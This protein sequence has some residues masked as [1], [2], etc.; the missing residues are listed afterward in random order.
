MDGRHPS[1][2]KQSTCC[3]IKLSHR[4]S[5]SCVIGP[6]MGIEWSRLLRTGV[7]RNADWCVTDY[8]LHSQAYGKTRLRR[9]GQR[10]Q[11]Q[12]PDD[13]YWAS[14]EVGYRCY[15]I[16]DAEAD[17]PR[18]I[19]VGVEEA[20]REFALHNVDAKSSKSQADVSLR[21]GQKDGTFLLVR[22]LNTVRLLSAYSTCSL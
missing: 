21:D 3:Y 9:L 1:S 13:W 2:C 20:L 8:A 12:A 14:Q 16:K 7:Q 5:K 18:R 10:L 15:L 19:D 6:V 4:H 22:W 11:W 17:C